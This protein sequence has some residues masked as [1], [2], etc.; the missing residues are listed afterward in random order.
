MSVSDI[1]KNHSTA[2]LTQTDSVE[3][4]KQNFSAVL[5]SV[6]SSDIEEQIATLEKTL[7]EAKKTLENIDASLEQ[8]TERLERLS[9]IKDGIE[10][11]VDRYDA[12][13]NN[14]NGIGEARMRR[15]GLVSAARTALIDEYMANGFSSKFFKLQLDLITKMRRLD[16]LGSKQNLLTAEIQSLEPEISNLRSALDYYEESVDQEQN[17]NRR[18][19]DHKNIME[20]RVQLLNGDILHLKFLARNPEGFGNFS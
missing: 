20:G 17:Y 10:E 18:F 16:E 9:R 12:A 5:T 1:T 11:K 2:D 3:N 19:I 6:R 7:E 13:K 14:L 15:E 8:S 4:Q